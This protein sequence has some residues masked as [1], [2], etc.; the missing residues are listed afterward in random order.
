MTDT[1]R[2]A[3]NFINTASSAVSASAANAAFSEN[4]FPTNF[5]MAVRRQAGINTIAHSINA[6]ADF[7]RRMEQLG[8]RASPE[9]M[10]RL[11]QLQGQMARNAQV[12]AGAPPVH[13]TRIRLSDDDE[14][15]VARVGSQ[16]SV[17]LRETRTF[18]GMSN[19]FETGLRETPGGAMM[20]QGF[21]DTLDR[22]LARTA[23]QEWQDIRS[24]RVNPTFQQAIESEVR[25]AMQAARQEG[26]EPE[27]S[28]AGYSR[29][30]AL[31]QALAFRWMREG[32][33]PVRS[34]HSIGSP[35]VGDAGFAQQMNR[36]ASENGALV[37]R[38]ETGGDIV[39]RLPPLG[40]QPAGNLL[41]HPSHL[42][43]D[44]MVYN[45]SEA[46]IARDAQLR[47][48]A[49]GNSFIGQLNDDVRHHFSG[50][51][52][53]VYESRLKHMGNV[54]NSRRNPHNLDQLT[55]VLIE[56]GS[57]QEAHL[58]QGHRPSLD[59][60][61]GSEVSPSVQPGQN[62]GISRPSHSR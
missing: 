11:Q 31:G 45:P 26:L 42:G 49:S 14:A 55:E 43:G 27:V 52:M 6:H 38:V 60:P 15:V 54:L 18:G 28:I 33:I 40:Y 44:V 10:Q 3:I 13:H 51:F 62:R 59:L 36:L 48:Q 17:F 2:T 30:G 35:M 5:E 7:F 53:R 37:L 1:Q 61:A 32:E 29:G 23:Q 57:P 56:G 24:G 12:M 50:Q 34:V 47:R 22:P 19:N 25:S 16:V 20:H 9:E 46:F 41:Y 58:L 21:L 39:P 4:F 8:D